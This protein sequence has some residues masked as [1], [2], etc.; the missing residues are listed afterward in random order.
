MKRYFF[1][2]ILITFSVF[3]NAQIQLS[4]SAKISLMTC[5]PWSGAVYAYYGHTALRVQDDSTHL[6]TVFNYGFFD[7]S[8]PNFIYHFV[9]GETDYILGTTSFEVFISEYIY[10]KVAVYEQEL[11]LT[12]PEKQQ[13]WEALYINQLPENR[14]YRYN[15]FYD[16]CSTR[17]R[18]MV[19]KFVGGKIIYPPTKEGQTYRDILHEC[20]QPYPWNKFGID[21]IIGAGADYP[22][23]VRAKMFIPSYLMGSFEGATVVKNDSVSYPLIKETTTVLDAANKGN[24]KDEQSVFSPIVV[25]FTLLFITILV[26]VVQYIKWNKTQ[27][28]KIYDTILFAIYGIGGFV[29]FSLM[30]F[31]EHPATN[32]NWNFVWMNIFALIFAVLFWV[33]PMKNVVNIY[34]FINFAVLTLF[35]LLWWLVPQ[36]LPVATIPFSM[37]LWLRSGTNVFMLTKRK[38]VNKRYVSSKYMKAGWGQ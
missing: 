16:N 1:T 27:L 14:G 7:P 6:D 19:E 31:S 4:D 23:D 35:L 25:A 3:T 22:I 17:P 32:P 37:S 13:L 18:D 24:S 38:K 9:R 26:S 15:Y 34:H 11:N 20:L 36:Q 5:G 30:F 33:K 10:K 21:L 8:Q 29:L 12:Q 2:I 28:P